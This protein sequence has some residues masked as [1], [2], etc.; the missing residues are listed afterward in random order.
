MRIKMLT[1][2]AGPSGYYPPGTIRDLPTKEAKYLIS[3]RYAVAMTELQRPK[4]RAV[5][6]DAEDLETAT[7]KG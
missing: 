4:E 5:V 1:I 2:A 3:K 6:P 7:V